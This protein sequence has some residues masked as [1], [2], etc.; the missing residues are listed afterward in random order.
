ME[1]LE[2]P[3]EAWRIYRGEGFHHRTELRAS[4]SSS[5]HYYKVPEQWHLWLSNKNPQSQCQ[6]ALLSSFGFNWRYHPGKMVSRMGRRQLREEWVSARPVSNKTQGR[7]NVFS[8]MVSP[9]YL[10]VIKEVDLSRGEYFQVSEAT[11]DESENKRIHHHRTD[12]LRAIMQS[13]LFPCP[14]KTPSPGQ[15][16]LLIVCVAL[17]QWCIR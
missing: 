2:A 10:S 5:R 16:K 6:S 8:L 13:P 15:T 14:P 12:W 3:G 1:V 9:N 4:S 7:F 17:S 11:A